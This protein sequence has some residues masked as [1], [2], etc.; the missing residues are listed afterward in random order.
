[1]NGRTLGTAV[2][3]VFLILLAGAQ[4]AAANTED[5][6][7]PSNPGEPKVDSGWQAGTCNAEPPE[8][9]A[10]V[11]SVGTP[12][13][14]FETAGAH[15]NWGFTQ[16][17]VRS[18]A[19]GETPVG[20]LK[21]VRVDLPVGLSVNPGATVHCPLAIFK[22]GASG[23][24]PESNVGTSQVT[25]SILGV[26][27]PPTAPLT[28]V[29]VYNVEP[30]PGEA[31]RFG[32]E[33]AGN[34]VF[35]EGDVAWS[36]DYHEG[37]TIHVPAA[38]PSALGGLLG[39]LG[40]KGLILKNR[41]VFNGRAGD[42]TFLTTPTTCFG[43]A[44][45]PG[46]VEGEQPNGPSGS[47]YSTFLRASSVQE[48]EQ[49]GYV[50]P[51][52]A[53]PAL[54]SPIP[55]ESSEGGPTEPKDCASIPYEPSLDVAP[56]T[57]QTN[58]PAAAEV[59]IEVP[60]LLPDFGAEENEQDS[61]HTKAATVTLPVGTG[62]NPSAA[63]GLQVCT[64]EQFGKGTTNPVQC[65]AGSIIGH[66]RVESPPLSD[67]AEPQPEEDLEGNVYVGKQLSRDPASGD[68]Y[69]IFIEAK[70]DRYGISVR[71]IGKVK[72]DPV[73]GQLST[74][75]SEA[76]QVPFTK[77]DLS[78]NGGPRAVLSSPPTCGP[79]KASAVMTPWS[80]KPP[81]TPSDSFTLSSAPGGGKCAKS[82][83]ERPFTPSFAAGPAAAKAGAFSPLT[84][85]IGRADGQQELKG[86]DVVL[87]PGMTGKLAGIPYCPEAAIAAAAANAGAAEASS[88]S[89]PTAS[90]VGTATVLSGTGPEPYKIAGKVFLS[91]PYHGAP[92]SLAV[93]TP[94]TA[95]PFDLGTVV[96]RV[97]LF[98]DPE[99]AQIH[100]ISDP[101]PDV[102]GGTQLSVRSVDLTMDRPNF[103]LNPT[104]CD[105]L[106]TT[107]ALLGG[108]SDPHNPAAFSAF[109][110][111]VPFQTT[112]CDAL[113][114]RPKLVTKL[115]GGRKITRRNQHP[116]LQATLTAREG[117]ANL[118]RAALT[119]PHALFLDQS[120]IGTICTR[121][122]LAA[123]DCPAR[124]VYGYARAKSPL[125]D[126]ELSGPVYL[127]SSSHELPDL[128][129]ALHGQVDI[130]LRG[131][132]SSTKGRMKTVFEPIPDV[133]VSKFVLTMKGGKKGLLVNS[134]DLCLKPDRAFLNFKAQNGKKLRK[135]KLP[136]RVPACKG[137]HKGKHQ[138]K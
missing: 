30:V 80:G 107:G 19:P 39:M 81:A 21:T 94:A 84:M 64:D 85:R 103:T 91:G 61:S 37:F 5:I 87:P 105:P 50:F 29:P 113:G 4:G 41:L 38:L 110:V 49:P 26:P 51:Q 79:D 44:Y 83:G 117:D 78:F 42:G 24:P 55:P 47:L 13:Q 15:P 130:R 52:S 69:R 106:A 111:S 70:S 56:G 72:A 116:K 62:I 20:E 12:D 133:A 114:F 132:I 122:Q 137:H 76:P 18:Q 54:E 48:E 11:C 86:A 119:L 71:L 102:F 67:E 104:S 100:A 16:F 127:T 120:H 27:S 6:I 23:C 40:E 31:A 75:I 98:V 73:T 125:L 43:P 46:W 92:L 135:K 22:A 32:L 65:P 128:L 93:V 68:E 60:H 82:L 124:S 57:S 2:A 36:G 138:K 1:V 58:S 28:E 88:P 95:G 77:F 35:L 90:Q 7:A 74:T 3:F 115:L 134:R 109:P 45:G 10:E 8:P 53:E 136:I 33:L 66:A 34:E 14:F 121:V 101:I 123:S 99:T 25:V 129:V 126:D 59:D 63:T 89:C 112:E 118:R 97:A 17:I 9:G 131:V 96:V 108:G